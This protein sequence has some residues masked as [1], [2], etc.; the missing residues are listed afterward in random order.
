MP[1]IRLYG[2]I[3]GLDV[4]AATFAR[5]LDSLKAD[6]ID[7][8]INSRGGDAFDGI[9]IYNAI[10]RHPAR[11]TVHI[12]GLAASAASFIA[13]AAD[14]IVINRYAKMMIHDASLLTIG[15][16]ADHA[17]SAALLDSISGIIA[18]IYADRAG[19]SPDLWRDR[20]ATDTWYTATEAVR[21]GLADRI[22][23]SGHSAGAQSGASPANRQAVAVAAAR[24][25]RT[26]TTK[27]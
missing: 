2:G 24:R 4:S 8:R 22:E 5:Q 23:A 15:N 18:Q 6:H 12:D 9:A 14:E 25:R 7:I 13:Q 20:M 1:E 19:G 3:D 11:T 17:A 26:I 21:V 16:A 27:G 10:A